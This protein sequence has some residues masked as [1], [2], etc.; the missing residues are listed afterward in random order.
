MR[1]IRVVEFT[2]SLGF[3]GTEKT[4]CA[5]SRLLN[6]EKFDVHVVALESDPVSGRE[7]ELRNHGVDMRISSRKHLKTYL[8]SLG[9]DIFH[10]HRGGWAESGPITAAKE[11][12]I[13]VV[14]EHNV[15][16]RV[17]N[18]VENDLIDCHIF[19]SY[20]CAARYQMWVRHPLVNSAYEILYYPVEIDSFDRYGFGDRDFSR[21]SIGRIGR[22]DNT[23]WE[24]RYLEALGAVVKAF[25]DLEFHVIGIT[26]EVRQKLINMGMG[27]NIVERPMSTNEKDIMDFYSSISV[28]TH[29]AD[30]GETFGL[31]LAEAM[32]AKLPVVTHHTQPPKDSAQAELIDNGYNGLVAVD[33]QMYADALTMLLSS[34]EN[35]RQVGQNGYEKARACYDA[36]VITR[37]LERI[38]THHARRAGI[39]PD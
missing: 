16:G 21:K 39:T 33:P 27:K 9:A 22:A 25:P 31:V 36:P 1:Q 2:N 11:A 30:M 20:S 15:F 37:G 4:L 12:G 34:P 7:N 24:F 26:P 29:F 18:S 17:D 28:M 10:I 8:E 5:F 38:F 14:I 6:R 13:P 19:I 3:G 35:A 32:A 23:K